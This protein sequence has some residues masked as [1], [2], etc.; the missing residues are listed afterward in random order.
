M[1]TDEDDNDVQITREGYIAGDNVRA[2]NDGFI[3]AVDNAGTG[4]V[5]LIKANTSDQIEV[6][7][8]VN[9]GDNEAIN[10]VLEKRVNDTGMTVAGQMWFRTDLV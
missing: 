8:D 6:G 2:A 10:F 5:D 7:A 3:T 4:S 9:F 1:F